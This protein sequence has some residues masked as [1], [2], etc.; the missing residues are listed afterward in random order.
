MVAQRTN[1][2]LD[3]NK[4]YS[5]VGGKKFQALTFFNKNLFRKYARMFRTNQKIKF[6]NQ[7]YSS[8]PDNG[9]ALHSTKL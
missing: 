5:L 4:S 1:R 6:K 8:K 7:E 3:G 2:D 9:I